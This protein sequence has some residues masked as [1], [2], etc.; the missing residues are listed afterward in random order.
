MKEQAEEKLTCT[1]YIL[2][3]ANTIVSIV[4]IA[5]ALGLAIINYTKKCWM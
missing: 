5:L 1:R 2:V 3:I 4:L